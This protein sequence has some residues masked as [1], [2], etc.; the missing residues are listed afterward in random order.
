MFSAAYWKSFPTFPEKDVHKKPF[1]LEKSCQSPVK[2]EVF[3]EYLVE[4]FCPEEFYPG[5]GKNF[6]AE[7][8]KIHFTSLQ[9]FFMENKFLRKYNSPN[10]YGFWAIS[11]GDWAQKS[12]ELSKMHFMC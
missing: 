5:F 3:S 8:T 6:K 7:L 10:A 9:E 2:A 12:T 1:F 11:L 4:I